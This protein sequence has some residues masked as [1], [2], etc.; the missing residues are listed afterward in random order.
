M[1]I[2]E[3]PICRDTTVVFSPS[4]RPVCRRL[5]VPCLP[6]NDA[7]RTDLNPGAML[8]R[9]HVCIC[10]P[11]V[12]LSLSL[13]A[14]VFPADGFHSPCHSLN[15]N[16]NTAFDGPRAKQLPASVETLRL[17][18]NTGRRPRGRP[19]TRFADV[20]KEDLKLSVCHRRGC[21]GW[22]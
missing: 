20:M 2:T 19:K 13:F 14:P 16:T 8:Y 10:T 21:G 5:D 7:N 15:V 6:A 3:I 1:L 12:L 9:S 11:P 22:G 4:P 18:T 17:G